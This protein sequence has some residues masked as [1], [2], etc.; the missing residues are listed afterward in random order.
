MQSRLQKSNFSNFLKI[1]KINLCKYKFLKNDLI[2]EIYKYMILIIDY[3][4]VRV[5]QGAK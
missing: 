4:K 5:D 3:E 2:F 1:I